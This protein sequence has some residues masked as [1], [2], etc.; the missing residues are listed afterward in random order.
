MTKMTAPRTPEQPGAPQI[1]LIFAALLLVLC[2][3]LREVCRGSGSFGECIQ[4]CFLRARWRPS[5]P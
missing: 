5:P 2:C 3:W 4:R 1:R